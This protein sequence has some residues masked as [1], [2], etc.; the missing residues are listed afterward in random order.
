M[1]DTGT[2][3]KNQISNLQALDTI[4]FAK[5]FSKEILFQ[6]LKNSL[7]IVILQ[8]C[9]FLEHIINLFCLNIWMIMQKPGKNP[10]RGPNFHFINLNPKFTS[11]VKII[12]LKNKNQFS[13]V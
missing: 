9:W 8:K 12:T 7:K 1:I 5:M 3:Q 13:F 6:K 2:A 11:K 4:N 10:L